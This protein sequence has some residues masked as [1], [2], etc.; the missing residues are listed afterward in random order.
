MSVCV[1][2]SIFIVLVNDKTKVSDCLSL[3][4]CIVIFTGK[5]KVYSLYYSFNLNCYGNWQDLRV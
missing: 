3:S 1:L 5:T 2:L 4:I